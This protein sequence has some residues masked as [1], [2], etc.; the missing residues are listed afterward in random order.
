[1][2]FSVQ[3]VHS[4]SL[5]HS[6]SILR[7]ASC[8]VCEQVC[9]RTLYKRHHTLIHNRRTYV[10]ASFPLLLSLLFQTHA[11]L[12]V[13]L[14]G[15]VDSS[16]SF[17]TATFPPQFL[18]R[19]AFSAMQP[20]NLPRVSR[21]VA[22]LCAILGDELFPIVIWLGMFGAVRL[23]PALV[24]RLSMSFP[25]VM[26]VPRLLL[27]RRRRDVSGGATSSAVVSTSISAA[28]DA[29]AAHLAELIKNTPPGSSSNG[30]RLS[31]GSSSGAYD[32]TLRASWQRF[33]HQ[34]LE[35]LV[36]I[37]TYS[38][39]LW[40]YLLFQRSQR[41]PLRD[42]AAAVQRGGGG[43]PAVVEL[44]VRL[45]TSFT[46]T[47][48]HASGNML[49]DTI[50]T[51]LSTR[52]GSWGSGSVGGGNAIG[53]SGRRYS[54]LSN[55]W[56]DLLVASC[57]STGL[58]FVL[59][60]YWVE[61]LT[62]IGELRALPLATTA[63]DAL[64]PSF[65]ERIQ[66]MLSA[67]SRLGSKESLYRLCC[68]ALRLQPQS[69]QR[70]SA[71][72]E[73]R[74]YSSP[75]SPS[76]RA[77]LQP[78]T[79]AAPPPP[80]SLDSGTLRTPSQPARVYLCGGNAFVFALSGFRF[81]YYGDPQQFTTAAS[82]CITDALDLVLRQARQRAAAQN[83][84]VSEALLEGQVWRP[85]AS[86]LSSSHDVVL[87]PAASLQ[88]LPLYM[89][90]FA[91]GASVGLVWRERRHLA[92]V[93][94]VPLLGKVVELLFPLPPPPLR[95]PE[96]LQELSP[97]RNV[98]L[99]H[100]DGR[101]EVSG[102]A[103]QL[104]PALK[105]DEPTATTMPDVSSAGDPP[106]PRVIRIVAAQDLFCPIKRTLMCDPV[107]TAD[108]FT[109][110]RDGIEEWLRGHNTAPL[111]NLYLGSAALRVNCRARQKISGLI[112]QYTTA[113]GVLIN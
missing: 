42:A 93:R 36:S 110:D 27:W 80:S 44:L 25:Q 30:I 95:L 11:R 109:Y 3:L 69:D 31:G 78:L 73:G 29:A 47:W 35:V 52:I 8:I 22:R 6:F 9:L 34:S 64:S 45:V 77:A 41:T 53:G 37:V 58:N 100:S 7:E 62:A 103:L 59:Q 55:G 13:A 87:A 5:S 104:A 26:D 21:A 15:C 81:A 67:L 16:S 113:M 66:F 107:Q 17:T 10:R 61:A 76:G 24:L 18:Y 86:S 108:G 70:S 57:V 60:T 14:I 112:L 96:A 105:A 75:P 90:N 82:N 99:L 28:A 72:E 97:E 43:R 46:S 49:F 74:A 54:S 85:P 1:M 50:V 20:T 71:A 33:Y 92:I 51:Y 19:T 88:L 106:A 4:V 2:Y 111:T 32:A 68:M 101:A 40:T 83:G 12:C 102:D 48:V 94:R 23:A 91:V 63:G 65:S 38:R 39:R 89:A 84:R 79:R 98:L 56:R